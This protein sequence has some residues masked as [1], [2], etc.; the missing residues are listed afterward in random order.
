[1]ILKNIILNIIFLT[2]IISGFPGKVFSQ[3]NKE[4]KP[5]YP[6]LNGHQFIVNGLIKSPFVNTNL[7]ST[8]GFATSLSTEIPLLNVPNDSTLNFNADI[9]F[10]NGVFEYQNAIQDWAAIW[11]NFNGIA[12]LGTNT[13]SLFVSGVTT[14]TTFNVGMLFKIK[15]FRKSIFSTSLGIKN[16]SATILNIFPFITAIIDSTIPPSLVT[17]LN[18][19]IGEIDVRAAFSP[20]RPWSIMSYLKGS[21]GETIEKVSIVNR[22]NYE[23]GASATYDLNTKNQFPVALGAGFRIVSNSPTLE[24]TKR[25]TQY[26]MLQ[27][28]YT[29]RKDFSLGL[30]SLY[31]RIPVNFRDL[32]INLTSF[33]FNWAYYF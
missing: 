4:D 6:I 16:T 18:P 14:N 11:A 7:K 24:Y 1:M 29:G 25:L 8:L 9:S 23:F 33:A 26:Y 17:N 20:G 27:L 32:T 21:Y 15:E 13:A 2:I 30:E 10:V 28:A 12:R 5:G 3:E 22:F 31:T 19:L